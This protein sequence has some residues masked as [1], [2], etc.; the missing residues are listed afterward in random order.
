MSGFK[1]FFGNR[2]AV[3]PVSDQVFTLYVMI[4]QIVKEESHLSI[5]TDNFF[6]KSDVTF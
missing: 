1:I 6:T 2:G 5:I 4:S 3:V